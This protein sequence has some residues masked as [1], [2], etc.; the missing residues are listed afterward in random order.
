[1][2]FSIIVQNTSVDYPPTIV[3]ADAM[4]EHGNSVKSKAYIDKEFPKDVDAFGELIHD[5]VDDLF[6]NKYRADI[7]EPKQTP[8]KR[9]KSK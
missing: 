1:M 8:V 4:D 5:I 9:G 6:P 2:K 7:P 3:R